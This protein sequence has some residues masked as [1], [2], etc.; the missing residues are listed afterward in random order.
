[1][2]QDRRLLDLFGLEHPI[3]QAPMAG[4]TTPALAAAVANAGALGSLGTAVYPVADWRAQVEATRA[5]TNRSIN[6][7]FFVHT[8]PV[9]EPARE[10]AVRARLAPLYAEFAVA[11]PA[12]A[13][14]PFAPFGSESLDTLLALRP[15]VASF[16]FGLPTADAVRAIKQAG[17]RILS[18][19]TTPA[20]AVRLEA[21]G[22]DAVIAQGWEAGGHRGTFAVPWPEG[23]IGTMALVP[24]VVDAVQIP[25]IAAGGIADGRGIAAALA[26]GAA[27]VQMGTAFLR[28]PEASTP[29]PHRAALGDPLRATQVTTAFTGRP[30]RALVNRFVAEMAGADALP[31]PAQASLVRPL[32]QAALQRGS[33]EFLSLW[34]GQAA[35]LARAMPAAELVQTLVR[36][37][38]SRLA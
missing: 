6:V 15:V 13:A 10:Q 20:E 4:F 11:P 37:A 12:P 9:I 7:N 23:Q 38:E 3:I 26:L 32:T 22:A 31:F 14:A 27:G 33:A 2:W 36:A 17:I 30:A 34:A 16:H 1:M 21:E 28:C 18:S 24:Q 19:A 35:G 5:L 25:V 8:P 29:P